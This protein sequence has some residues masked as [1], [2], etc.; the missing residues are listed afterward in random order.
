M[1]NHEK[2]LTLIE[3]NKT[4]QANIYRSENIPKK[5]YKYIYL[6]KIPTCKHK[7]SIESL[8][9]LKLKT[10]I[11]NNFWLSTAKNL[12]DPFEIKTLFVEEE[13]LKKYNYPVEV[14]NKL[15]DFFYNAFLIGCFSSNLTNNMPMWAHYANNHTGFCVEYKI[16]KPE[17]FY[18][19][20]YE[21]SRSPASNT[22]MKCL[23]LMRKAHENTITTKEKNDLELYTNLIYHNS[24]IKSDMWKYENE[25]RLLLPQESI[26]SNPVENGLL[27]N[28]D[29]IGIK[30]SAIY[31]GLSCNQYKDR[32]IKIGRDLGI[33]IYQM[34]FNDMSKSYDLSYKEI[35]SII[36]AI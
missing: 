12:N 11:D 22:F 13:K 10:L 1:F 9:E 34:Y 3:N 29:T 17:L 6:D 27:V 18:P 7:C 5:L 2:Y 21:P 16:N 26:L 15:K 4:V 28:N 33:K 8:N 36:K 19:I 30:I 23:Y 20:F 24:I 31:L 32:L 14:I 35:K 25:Y